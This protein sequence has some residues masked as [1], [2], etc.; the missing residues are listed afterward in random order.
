[1]IK[2][3]KF[4]LYPNKSQKQLLQNTLDECR[5][6]YNYMLA[7]KINTYHSDNIS[8]SKYKLDKLLPIVKEKHPNIQQVHSQI[9][10][11]INKRIDLAFQSFFRRIKLGETPGFPRFKGYDRYDSFTFK[12]SGFQLQGN[13]KLQL[14]KIGKVKIKQHRKIDGNI[15]TLTIHKN[16]VNHWFACFSV[17]VEQNILSNN[18]KAVGIDLGIEKFAVLSDT[19]V[20]ENPKHLN[21]N[22]KQL[23]KQSKRYSNAKTKECKTKQKYKLSKLHLKI[24]NSRNDFLHKASRNIINNN[25]IIVVE[26]LDIR[27]MQ[28]NNYRILN[29]YIGDAGWNTFINMLFYKAEEAGRLI[30]KVNPKNTSKTCSSCGYINKD[31]ELKDRIYKCPQCNIEINRDYNASLN[32]LGLGLQSL[33]QQAKLAAPLEAPVL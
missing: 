11:D 6:L 13:N 15:K 12:Q 10:Q 3:Y 7:L 26:N 9:L 29:R 1:M 17:E 18:N 25:D 31:L 8:L 20:V 16:N 28:D 4:R 24:K 5:W 27:N 23:Q 14:S 21:K 30:I 32:I 22:L 19:T 2:T 33:R